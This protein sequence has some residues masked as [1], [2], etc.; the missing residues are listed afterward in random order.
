MKNSKGG[1]IFVSLLI[2]VAILAVG[3]GV[4][5]YQNKKT[6]TP[7]ITGNETQLTNNQNHSDWKIYEN[8]KYKFGIQYPQI[9]Y[10]DDN[11]VR[12]N[13]IY[14]HPVTKT[15][16][17]YPDNVTISFGASSAECNRF[18]SYKKTDGQT[19]S[20]GGVVFQHVSEVVKSPQNKFID[21]Y[22]V[23]DKYFYGQDSICYSAILH[24]YTSLSKGDKTDTAGVKMLSDIEIQKQWEEIENEINTYK[25]DFKEIVN[26]FKLY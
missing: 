1:F 2:I 10:I 24:T 19:L 3:G 18:A 4:Y 26:T 13:G 25:S 14:L 23:F 21:T 11:K 9:K 7:V 5:L 16:H 20:A 12:E 22:E 8:T 15:T 6:E 17:F